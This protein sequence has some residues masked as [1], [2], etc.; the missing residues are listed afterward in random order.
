MKQYV[1]T[2]KE[3]RSEQKKIREMM[4]NIYGKE[5]A[6]ELLR[7]IALRKLELSRLE[8]AAR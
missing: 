5:T 1:F 4:W 8:R 6:G 3:R 7:K 2:N